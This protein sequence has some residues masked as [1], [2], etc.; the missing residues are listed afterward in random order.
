MGLEKI[1]QEY[2]KLRDSRGHIIQNDWKV[3]EVAGKDR[4]RFLHN[5]VSQNVEEQ[6]IGERRWSSLLNSKGKIIGFFQVW[7]LAEKFLLLIHDSQKDAVF[8]TLDMYLITEDVSFKWWENVQVVSTFVPS[9]EKLNEGYAYETNK[10]VE[11]PIL[12]CLVDDYFIPSVCMIMQ[13]DQQKFLQKTMEIANDLYDAIRIQSLFPLPGKDYEDPI[14]LEVPFMHR[15]VSFTKGCYVGQ[16]TIARLHARGLNVSRKL[17]PFACE[18]DATVSEKDPVIF[19]QQEVGKVTSLAFS[20]LEKRKI[21]MAWIHRSAFGKFVT[22]NNQ[23]I[24]VGSVSEEG[25]LEITSEKK[26]KKDE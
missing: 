23:N 1:H 5:L 10:I 4:V 20:A 25:H 18:I 15:A 16:E 26:M 2:Q 14:P 9:K 21:G 11:E 8:K 17:F 24:R 19:D 12:R 7:K 22:V 6:A 3:L 13:P